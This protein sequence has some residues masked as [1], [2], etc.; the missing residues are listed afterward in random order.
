MSSLSQY[1]L[2]PFGSDWSPSLPMVPLKKDPLLERDLLLESNDLKQVEDVSAKIEDF[3]AKIENFSAKEKFCLFA[4]ISRFLGMSMNARPIFAQLPSFVRALYSGDK[5]S[6]HIFTE[7]QCSEQEFYYQFLHLLDVFKNTENSHELIIFLQKFHTVFTKK[8]RLDESLKQKWDLKSLSVHLLIHMLKTNCKDLFDKSSHYF[9]NSEYS[10]NSKVEYTPPEKYLIALQNTQ[11]VS[12]S[13]NLFVEVM[14]SRK[15]KHVE[16]TRLDNIDPFKIPYEIEKKFTPLQLAFLRKVLDKIF[17]KH[18]EEMNILYN[19]FNSLT[20]DLCKNYHSIVASAEVVDMLTSPLKIFAIDTSYVNTHLEAYE[21]YLPR[22]QEIYNAITES[23]CSIIRILSIAKDIQS[24]FIFGNTDKLK[25]K[26]ISE[27][28]SYKAIEEF[29]FEEVTKFSNQISKDLDLQLKIIKF[30]KKPENRELA[31]I[32]LQCGEQE[33][34]FGDYKNVIRWT[35]EDALMIAQQPEYNL[36]ICSGLE[37]KNNI[38]NPAKECPEVTQRKPSN[39]KINKKKSPS[40]SKAK[41][42]KPA[43]P[44]AKAMQ[45]FSLS[46][47]LDN[48]RLSFRVGFTF[49]RTSNKSLPYVEEALLNTENLLNNFLCTFNRLYSSFDNLPPRVFHSF[50]IDCIRYGTLAAEQMLSAFDRASNNIKDSKEL[51]EH[52]SHNLYRILLSCKFTEFSFPQML[53]DFILQIR[54]GEVWLRNLDQ[55]EWGG[56]LLQNLLYK[57]KLFEEGKNISS[58]QAIFHEILDFS[59]NVGFLVFHLQKSFSHLPS[60]NKSSIVFDDF[61]KNWENI[62]KF[63]K[64]KEIIL[65]EKSALIIVETP[66]RR[67]IQFLHEKLKERGFN[68]MFDNIF[69]HLLVHLETEISLSPKLKLT[70][71]HLHCGNIFLLNQII[72]EEILQKL[73]YAFNVSYSFEK[74]HN[75]WAMMCALGFSEEEF[76]NSPQEIEFLKSGKDIRQL[77]RYIASYD[78]SKRKISNEKKQGQ[79]GIIDHVDSTLHKALELSH[80][81]HFVHDEI[82]GDGFQGKPLKENRQ[83]ALLKSVEDNLTVMLSIL[84]RLVKKFL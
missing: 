19:A 46:Q 50:A 82:L 11:L 37:R 34:I 39:E 81:Q 6:S 30:L 63:L 56:T 38:F 27:S 53:R 65:A 80:H 29:I 48:I 26:F 5:Y 61:Y 20:N 40:F 14:Y 36:L 67:A 4:D 71:L 23:S 62:I 12:Y 15:Q 55:C 83:K 45:E 84:H 79:R 7:L 22:V 57:L 75:L 21:S 76:L 31:R 73:I 28:L 17:K 2:P 18:T 72:L 16:N 78:S 60:A 52:L 10:I 54:G 69:N 35:L 70:E 77:V 58:M 51:N 74:G 44:I 8:E 24:Y 59:K 25:D 49:L 33:T 43:P 41:I 42:E 64:R 13:L 68:K 32:R 3:S 47:Q 1:S 9:T 66:I